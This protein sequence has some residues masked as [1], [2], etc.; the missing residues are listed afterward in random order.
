MSFIYLCNTDTSDCRCMLGIVS[1]FD[2][3]PRHVVFFLATET[4]SYILTLIIYTY[5]F[6]LL[7]VSTCMCQVFVSVFVVY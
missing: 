3:I 2:M 1:H 6:K 4:C 5:F 7:S